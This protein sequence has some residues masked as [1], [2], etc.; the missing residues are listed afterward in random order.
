M[1]MHIDVCHIVPIQAMGFNL[2]RDRY[3]DTGL[4]LGSGL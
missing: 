3:I 2:V 1:V 4:G